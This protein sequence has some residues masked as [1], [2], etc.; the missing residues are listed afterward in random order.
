MESLDVLTYMR[1]WRLGVPCEPR[2]ALW[3]QVNMFYELGDEIREVQQV[4]A[5]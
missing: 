2:P 5:E 3:G 1:R 4:E